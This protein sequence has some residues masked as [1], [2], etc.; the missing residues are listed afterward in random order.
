MRDTYIAAEV[1]ALLYAAYIHGRHDADLNELRAT[2]VEKREPR[3]TRERRVA[4]RIADMEQAA[5]RQPWN[6]WR[7]QYPGGSVDFETGRPV[8]RLG[9]VA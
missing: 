4:G 9:V 1:R 5:A 7:G 2:W 6:T 3:I 8:R